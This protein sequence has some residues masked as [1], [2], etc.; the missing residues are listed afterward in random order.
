MPLLADLDKNA[1]IAA[2]KVAQSRNLKYKNCGTNNH[3]ITVTGNFEMI[4]L[5]MSLF[6]G[7]NDVYAKKWEN[8]KKAASGYSPVCL[9]QW[10]VGLCGKAD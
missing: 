3:H 4:E 6:K 2:I 5:F 10:K 1:N 9:N 7:R 8:K